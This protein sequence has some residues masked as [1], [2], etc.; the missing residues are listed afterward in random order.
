MQVAVKEHQL[1]N[2]TVDSLEGLR[3]IEDLAAR[4]RVG[5][6]SSGRDSMEQLMKA[7]GQ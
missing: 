6:T 7:R 2:R 1:S 3:H 5:D 4:L